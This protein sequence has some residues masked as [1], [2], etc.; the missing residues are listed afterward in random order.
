MPLSLVT[1]MEHHATAE[2]GQLHDEIKQYGESNLDTKIPQR[3]ST[4]FVRLVMQIAQPAVD[5][6]AGKRS[7]T[8]REGLVWSYVLTIIN[9]SSMLI[10]TPSST[11]AAVIFVCGMRRTSQQKPI[12]AVAATH[13]DLP[14]DHS[15]GIL[16]VQWQCK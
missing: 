2:E 16:R 11:T 1:Q 15:M 4:K 6:T 13:E 14:V 8:G 10:P 12:A 9:L 7:V 5:D 3:N